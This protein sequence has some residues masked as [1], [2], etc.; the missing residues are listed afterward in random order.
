VVGWLTLV[1]LTPDSFRSSF[2]F[3]LSFYSVFPGVAVGVLLP[4]RFCS[5]SVPGATARTAD[6]HHRAIGSASCEVPHHFWAL[7]LNHPRDWSWDNLY[8]RLQIIALPLTT[9]GI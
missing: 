4:H 8:L 1:G 6:P 7:S 9:Q 5:E 3:A 2:G